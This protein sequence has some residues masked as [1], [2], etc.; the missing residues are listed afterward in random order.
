MMLIADVPPADTGA[1]PATLITLVVLG[2]LGWWF[3]KLQL[4]PLRKCGRCPKPK[5]DGSYHRCRHCGG[6]PERLKTSA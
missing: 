4:D 2:A 3:V 6:K 1:S 5:A